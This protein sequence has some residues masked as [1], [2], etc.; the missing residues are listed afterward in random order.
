[1]RVQF[2]Q[3]VNE[4]KARDRQFVLP[5]LPMHTPDPS[6]LDPVLEEEDPLYTRDIDE[7]LDAAMDEEETKRLDEEMETLYQPPSNLP[8]TVAEARRMVW[9]RGVHVGPK[10]S[11]TENEPFTVDSFLRNQVVCLHRMDHRE[12][13]F[14][15]NLREIHRILESVRLLSGLHAMQRHLFSLPVWK[16]YGQSARSPI[17]GVSGTICLLCWVACPC[18]R[19]CQFQYALEKSMERHQNPRVVQ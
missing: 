4:A 11:I 12:E 2:E 3:L 6:E 15:E 9:S 18:V 19:V 7:L 13:R 8:T 10:G 1:M 16:R 14:T 17:V 5:A